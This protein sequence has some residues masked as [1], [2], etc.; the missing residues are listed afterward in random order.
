MTQDVFDRQVTSALA[1]IDAGRLSGLDQLYDLMSSSVYELSLIVTGSRRA[2][3]DATVHT[4]VRVWS[5]AGLR[6]PDSTGP[7]WVLELACDSA[8]IHA[9]QVSKSQ[10]N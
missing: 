8:H 10:A 9:S 5:S 7:R 3:E 4:F 1:A 2:A 6:S